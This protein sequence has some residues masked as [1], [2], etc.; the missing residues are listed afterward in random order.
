VDPKHSDN[1]DPKK[2]ADKKPF[3]KFKLGLKSR[4]DVA[5]PLQAAITTTLSFGKTPVTSM[6][7]DRFWEVTKNKSYIGYTEGT[8]GAYQ[9]FKGF[10]YPLIT[11][12][13]LTL[14]Q[15]HYDVE[16]TKKEKEA[17]VNKAVD[18]FSKLGM[19][20]T[21]ESLDTTPSK[22]TGT[23][24]SEP[25]PNTGHPMPRGGYEPPASVQAIIHK[26]GKGQTEEGQYGGRR[27]ASTPYENRSGRGSFQS[28]GINDNR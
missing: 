23:E 24:R 20:L 1:Y 5:S 16:D 13:R 25:L 28:L 27:P 15:L 19:D 8:V 26:S 10:V 3:Y 17:Y 14:K 6:T 9:D 12:R 22:P 11:A 18:M 4:G 21:D 2:D 7:R